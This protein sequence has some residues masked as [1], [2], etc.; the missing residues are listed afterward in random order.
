MSK[1]FAVTILALFLLAIC[2]GMNPLTIPILLWYGLMNLLGQFAS[3][4]G[5]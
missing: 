2:I 3:L 4:F 5:F 1:R